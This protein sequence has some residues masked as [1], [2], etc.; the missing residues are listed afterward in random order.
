MVRAPFL[1]LCVMTV[2]A[3]SVHRE[4][5]AINLVRLLDKTQITH[6][7]ATTLF[8]LVTSAV[9]FPPHSND[10]QASVWSIK[11]GSHESGQS[12]NARVIISDM[13][14]LDTL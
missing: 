9:T 2:N 4:R 6:V 5:S 13:I 12:S 3:V 7:P 1:S 8:V 10:L 14:E 11:I